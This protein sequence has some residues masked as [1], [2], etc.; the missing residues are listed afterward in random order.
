MAGMNFE[1]T[2]AWRL[3][4]TLRKRIWTGIRESAVRRDFEFDRQIYRASLSVMN[5]I[6]EGWE[7]ATPPEQA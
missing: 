4:R 5:N 3:A 1:D 6:A 7:A 2:D